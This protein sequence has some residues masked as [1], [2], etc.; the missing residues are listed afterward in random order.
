MPWSLGQRSACSPSGAR[1]PGL[2][3]PSG[4]GRAPGRRR[5]PEPAPPGRRRGL[6][7]RGA[8]GPTSG[9]SPG[10]RLAPGPAPTRSPR[11]R[12]PPQSPRPTGTLA[13]AALA[14]SPRRTGGGLPA[15]STCAG[16]PGPRAVS[17]P[18]SPAAPAVAAPA[19]RRDLVAVAVSGASALEAV[20][21][22][23][24]LIQLAQGQSASAFEPATTDPHSGYIG[25]TRP[26][27]LRLLV[28]GTNPTDCAVRPA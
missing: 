17:P 25:P 4:L 6:L 15:C 1:T 18:C 14:S 9:D 11:R 5:Q 22:F 23:R 24:Q 28:K 3:P 26:P 20:S 13:M 8:L 27:G 10:R 19:G 16:R 7:H 21:V 12:W 2:A